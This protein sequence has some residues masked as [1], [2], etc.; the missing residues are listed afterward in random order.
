[1]L[2]RVVA[3]KAAE[4]MGQSVRTVGGDC[5]ETSCLDMGAGEALQYQDHH[6]KY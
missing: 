5:P 2:W 4:Y 3:Q 6:L 1:M